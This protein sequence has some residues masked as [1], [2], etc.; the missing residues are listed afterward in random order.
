MGAAHRSN[1]IHVAAPI[2]EIQYGGHFSV[3]I[4]RLPIPAEIHSSIDDHILSTL[5]WSL[6]STSMD[7]K[8]HTALGRV[9][10]VAHNPPCF[11]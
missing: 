5:P 11:L 6:Q 1:A 7:S 3:S 4:I 10:T 8:R 9:L 2:L